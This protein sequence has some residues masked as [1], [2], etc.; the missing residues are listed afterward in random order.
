M[1]KKQIDINNLDVEILTDSDK[2]KVEGGNIWDLA[3]EIFET[4]VQYSS[5]TG[6][7]VVG[8]ANG[9][10]DTIEAEMQN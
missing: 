7:L 8:I 10:L 4:G 9:V 2:Q 1:K 3:F 5:L 6:A